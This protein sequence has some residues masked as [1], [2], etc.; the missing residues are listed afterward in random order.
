[1]TIPKPKR[2]PP[3]ARRPIARTS[4]PLKRTRIAKRPK[5]SRK[6]SVLYAD[7]LWSQIVR[8]RSDTCQTCGI[9]PTTQAAHGIDRGYFGTRWDLRNGFASCGGCNRQSFYRKQAWTQRL[10]LELFGPALF[11][12][13]WTL[14]QRPAKAVC[15]PDVTRAL[16]AVLH[17]GG[18][19]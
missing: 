5:A 9:R 14:A 16:E 7:S 15:L 3:K 10:R 17:T 18:M 13:L 8:R 12:E 2:T 4:K 6:K 1:M 11:D 19:A